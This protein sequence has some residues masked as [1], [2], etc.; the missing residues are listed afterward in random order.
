MLCSTQKK[1]FRLAAR[2]KVLGFTLPTSTQG[3]GINNDNNE[4]S[5]KMRI[6]ILQ[7]LALLLAQVL[8]TACVS[9]TPNSAYD[10]PI[11][12][13]MF[14][15]RNAGTLDEQLSIL[16]RAG[17]ANIETVDTQGVTP[18]ELKMLLDKHN[19]NVISAHVPINRLRN[20]LD[21][22]IAQQKALGNKVIVMPYL[23]PEQRPQ[24][25]SGWAELG[26]ELGGYAD[27]VRAAGM[28]MAYHNH[29]FEFV[30][31]DG[32]TA[33]EILFDAAGPNLK[34]QVD[35]AWVARGG[36]DPAEFLGHLRGRVISIHAKD[37]APA[38]TASEERGFAT[39]GTGVLDWSSILPAARDAGARWYI[40]EHDMPLDAEAVLTQGNA[41]LKRAL[42]SY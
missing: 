33:L 9:V 25:A 23:A 34:S 3:G 29:D 19:I 26:R 32:K 30:T 35:V 14:T 8:I 28:T 18:A 38:G 39:L 36:Y 16:N 1:R 37:N 4:E 21:T 12:A 40:L 11:A 22:V 2:L 6:R 15:L 31:F 13:Q 20:E 17:V 27:S 7:G 10:Q 24:N 41:Y 5:T 42:S